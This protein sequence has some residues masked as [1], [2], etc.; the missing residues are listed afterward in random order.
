[1]TAIS[2]ALVLIA[3][4]AVPTAAQEPLRWVQPRPGTTLT[5]G[6]TQRF[7]PLP[8]CRGSYRGG[9]HPG[10]LVGG[11]CQIG[12][13]GGAPVLNDYE[14][15]TGTGEWR[16]SEAVN[17]A[18]I[19]G[20]EAYGTP[21]PVCRARLR[22][23][24]HP[25]K[26]VAGQCSVAWGDQEHMLRGF[27]VLYAAVRSIDSG[28]P[29][30]VYVKNGTSSPVERFWIDYRG[31]AVSYGTIAPGQRIVQD[32]YA[33]HPWLYMSGG[34][35]VR[36]DTTTGPSP[37]FV[38]IHAYP[39]TADIEAGPIWSTV[40]AETKCPAVCGRGESEWTKEWRTTVQ[41]QMSVCQCKGF[42]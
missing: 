24:V 33:T 15:L 16:S 17:G 3:A 29:V 21:L 27:E 30:R 31:N 23:A 18:F 12:W 14:V 37:R 1:M 25:G 10:K 34:E 26:I 36:V 7:D 35:V 8:I 13:G 22:G 19:G 4:I 32:T 38:G 9:V 6:G 39:T 2:K 42:L 28:T 11:V 5:E 20:K 40:D 41:G